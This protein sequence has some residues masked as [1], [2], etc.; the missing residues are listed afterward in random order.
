MKIAFSGAQVPSEHKGLNGGTI[1]LIVI[2]VVVG[3]ALIGT[4]V[5]WYLR[6]K[7]LPNHLKRYEQL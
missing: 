2:L 4:G 3:V 1:A 6:R 7:N 5:W